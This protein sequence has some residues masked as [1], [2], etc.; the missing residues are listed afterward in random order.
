MNG[1]RRKKRGKARPG[2]KVFCCPSLL[3]A[4]SGCGFVR[5]FFSLSCE[6]LKKSTTRRKVVRTKANYTRFTDGQTVRTLCPVAGP[7][8]E[9]AFDRYRWRAV[10]NQKETKEGAGAQSMDGLMDGRTHAATDE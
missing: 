3:P 5:L 2:F 4:T 1:K 8:L 7:F 10:E 6:R 9:L